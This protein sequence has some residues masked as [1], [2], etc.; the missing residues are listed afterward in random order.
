M[1]LGIADLDQLEWR[2]RV[3]MEDLE[4]G[5]QSG[6]GIEHLP[7]GTHGNVSALAVSLTSLIADQDAVLTPAQIAANQD[8]YNPTGTNAAATLLDSAV[9]LRLESDAARTITGIAAPALNPDG[10]NRR[11]V[12]LWCLNRGSYA[13]TLAHN[14]S[15][16]ASANR[17]LGPNAAD[18]VIQPGGAVRLWYD[19]SSGNW[20]VLQIACGNAGTYTPTLTAVTNLSGTPNAYQC[21]WSRV[22]NMV[23]VSGRFGAEPTAAS[24]TLTEL[25]ISLPV[26]SAISTAQN[27]GGTATGIT[28]TTSEACSIE[29]DATNDRALVRWQAASTSDHDFFFTFG[30]L[31]Q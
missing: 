16:S 24:P 14:S 25:G 10:S 2:T 6:W 21:Q 13:I 1:N 26:A 4:V 31:V 28:S 11:G 9:V 18:A 8:N 20:R 15:S 22:G 17:I 12:F 5:I 27:V 30:Y 3:A 23:T 29:G 7:D 19:A